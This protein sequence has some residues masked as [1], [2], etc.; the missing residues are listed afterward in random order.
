LPP[1]PDEPTFWQRS[2]VR[3]ITVGISALLTVILLGMLGYIAMG[4]SPFDALFMVWITVSGVGYGEVRPMR[5]TPERIH[6]MFVIAFGIVSV[7]YTVAGFLQFLT[8]G[9]I[10]SLL[11]HKRVR[12][13]IETLK[14]H[15]IVAGYGRM[16][17]LIC[18]ELHQAGEAFVLIETLPD[19]VAEIERHGFLY[20]L[21]DATEEK[22]LQEAGL[23]RARALVTAVP[24]DADSVFITLTARELAPNVQ[25]VARAELPSTQKKLHQA[26]ANHVVLPAA[27]GA[28]RIASLLT[29]P[30]AVEFLELVTQRSSLAIEMDE[31]PLDADSQLTGHTLR[32][33][34]I[35][36]LTG[37]IVIAIKRTSGNV[38]FPPAGDLPFGPG[39]SIVLV[40]RRANL[41]QFRRQFC[42][43]SK[44]QRHNVDFDEGREQP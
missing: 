29:N 17:S 19:R 34:D 26:G 12:R 5:S 41:D 6:T 30:S 8:E 21:G 32:D 1:L 16:G 40:G 37:V 9:E 42:A 13:Q 4:W 43:R 22:V 36:R 2:S 15:I 10:Q 7:A 18:A 33:A 3:R 27:I 38:E 28:H 35:G 23:P 39:D 11:G 14:D 25:I 20:V 31:F 44:N 24:S